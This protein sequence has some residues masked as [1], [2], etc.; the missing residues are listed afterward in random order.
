M[1][2]GDFSELADHYAKHR[3]DYAPAVVE[4][5]VQLARGRTGD[6]R[7]PRAV[8]VGAGTGIFT[9]M[10]QQAGCLCAAV[11]PCDEMRA[12]GAALSPAIEFR[13]GSAEHV[14]LAAGSADLVTM[15]SS[16]HWADFEAAVATF[17]RLLV[18]RGIF[19]AVWNPRDLDP[20]P[21]LQEIEAHLHA[22]VPELRR[23][24]SGRSELTAG[25][26]ARLRAVGCFRDV[27][28]L[29]G[30]HVIP[31]ERERYL[32]AWRSV[33]DVRVQAG[34][35]RFTEFLAYVEERT[36][37]LARIEAHYLTRAWVALK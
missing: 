12:Q 27:L 36:A 29:E 24:S 31:M 28:Y 6:G 30:R 32:G 21:L 14:D 5:L 20:S 23:V 17:D 10:L 3:P 15:A 4:T 19:A 34:E 33:N 9:R 26:E 13:S 2:H 16:F 11:E 35:K 37:D 8:D 25:L 22:L 7:T 1:R 18:E